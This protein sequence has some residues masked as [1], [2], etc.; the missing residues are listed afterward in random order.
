MQARLAP[1]KRGNHW[2]V[3]TVFFTLAQLYIF[4]YMSGVFH[5]YRVMR[6]PDYAPWRAASWAPRGLNRWLVFWEVPYDAAFNFEFLLEWGG[7]Y[8]PAIMA[9]ESNRWVAS[10]FLHSSFMHL[11]SNVVT[12]LL[13]S[14]HLEAHYGV[15]RI[16]TIWLLSGAAG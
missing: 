7:R 1:K 6:D 3:W 4:A 15:W 2:P 11:I 16:F 10:I 8:G 12:F 9:G 14:N 5:F 13:L